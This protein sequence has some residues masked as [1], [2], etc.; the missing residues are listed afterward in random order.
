MITP[1]TSQKSSFSGG[2]DTDDRVELAPTP[3]AILIR[4]SDHPTTHLATAPTPLRAF[5]T[6][7][8]AGTLGRR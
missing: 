2:S 5:F 6:T 3:T 1:V 7:L 8:K 4:E